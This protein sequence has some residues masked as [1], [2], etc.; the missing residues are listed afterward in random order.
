M[1]IYLDNGYVNYGYIEFLPEPFIYVWGGRGTGKTYGVL[2]Y[3]IENNIRFLFMRRTLAQLK[4]S[5]S[6]ELCVFKRLNKDKGWNYAAFKINENLYAI[7]DSEIDK[8]GRVVPVGESI[9]LMGAL[10][11]FANIRG[12][13]GSDI[14]HIILD[15][16]VPELHERRFPFPGDAL[17]NCYE[18]VNRNRELEGKP[19]V[20]LVCFTNSNTERSDIILELN[21]AR[22]VHRLFNSNE[23]ITRN[24]RNGKCALIR[25]K[26]SPISARKAETALYQFM[27][28]SKFASMAL[29]NEFAYDVPSRIAS[30]NLSQYN[31]IVT[32]GDITIYEH[33]SVYEYYI[34]PHKSG[35]CESYIMAG[36]HQARFK[37]RYAH[38]WG[39]YLDGAC[40]FEDYVSELLF[41]EAFNAKF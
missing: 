37:R 5:A 4:A 28:G 39:S 3:F 29:N 27:K 20:K 38:I 24:L 32:A 6:G 30:R 18:T 13:D 23:W 9:G 31:P 8:N 35:D 1:K 34:T 10:S 16:F 19:P 17:M 2:E 11:V 22:D 26:D 40:V 12:F 25:L 7:H 21:L 14:T 33:K 36:S 41:Q 15:E